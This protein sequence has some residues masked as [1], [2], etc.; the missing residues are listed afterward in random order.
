[1]Q[2]LQHK[3]VPLLLLIFA[4]FCTT[5]LVTLSNKCEISLKQGVRFIWQNFFSL[6]TQILLVINFCSNFALT[7]PEVDVTYI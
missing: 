5:M 2:F 6:C 3:F 7:L 1:M 4:E